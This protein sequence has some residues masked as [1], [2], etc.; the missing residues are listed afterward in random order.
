MRAILALVLALALLV[1]VAVY[2][3]VGP[4][5][6]KETV[7]SVSGSDVEMNAAIAKARA[8][9]PEFWKQ[10]AAPLPGTDEY[11]LKIMVRDG[12]AAEHLWCSPV[13]GTAE[14]A[15]CRIANVPVSVKTVELDQW[16]DVRPGDISDWYYRQDGRLHG[17]QTVRAVLSKVSKEE[18]EALKAMLAPE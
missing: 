5:A 11:S 4:L 8:T 16:I 14:K 9:L 13:K 6:P 12:P 17:A 1:G 3:I 7:V 15:R 18:A 2:L 10:H